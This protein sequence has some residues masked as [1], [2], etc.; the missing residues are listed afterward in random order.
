VAVQG[1]LATR[2]LN[3]DK[4]V[5][6]VN[7]SIGRKQFIHQWQY[8][9]VAPEPLCV[10]AGIF[11]LPPWKLEPMACTRNQI[12]LGRP[13]KPVWADV[14]LAEHHRSIH[15]HQWYPRGRGDAYR[16]HDR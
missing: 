6:P 15:R 11:N 1:A 5:N 16:S 9:P 2:K 14:A 12:R 13:A 8:K 10:V 7:C 4:A 3:D